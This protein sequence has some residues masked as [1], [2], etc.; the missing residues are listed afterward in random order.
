MREGYLK[1]SKWFRNGENIWNIHKTEKN[2]N[3]SRLR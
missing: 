1:A 3:N 2:Q